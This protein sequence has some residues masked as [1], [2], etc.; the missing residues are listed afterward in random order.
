MTVKI[1]D[2][3]LDDMNNFLERKKFILNID[4]YPIQAVS[5]FGYHVVF[6]PTLMLKQAIHN[7]FALFS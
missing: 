4:T 6:V 2:K 3:Q 5:L 7:D 1:V